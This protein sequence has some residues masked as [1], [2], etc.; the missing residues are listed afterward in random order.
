MKARTIKIF[1]LFIFISLAGSG[2]VSAQKKG[3]IKTI[4]VE[5]FQKKVKGSGTIQLVDVRTPKEFTDGHLKGATNYNVLDSTL[6]RNISNLNRRKAVFVYC[7]SGARSMRAAEQ[8]KA[9]GFKVFNME[10]GITNWNS[11]NLP[12]VK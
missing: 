3:K 12:T 7:K 9:A 8:L 6:Y 2:T 5:Q 11:K 4:T 10:G 1:I